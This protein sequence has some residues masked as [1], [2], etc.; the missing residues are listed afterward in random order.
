MNCSIYL[1]RPYITTVIW[2]FPPVVEW[3]LSSMETVEPNHATNYWCNLYVLFIINSETWVKPKT[4]LNQT[5]FTLSSTK[6]LCNFNLCKPSTCINWTNYSVQ[7]GFSLDRFYCCNIL[8]IIFKKLIST[9]PSLKKQRW[10]IFYTPLH[11]NP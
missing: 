8:I 5:D 4:C 7:K 2:S 6:S 9:Y 11:P 3:L 10:I 1:C